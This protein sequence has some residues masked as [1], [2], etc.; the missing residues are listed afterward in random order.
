MRHESIADSES[1]FTAALQGLAHT[2]GAPGSMVDERGVGRS[3]S[4]RGGCLQG[5]L[6]PIGIWMSL[7]GGGRTEAGWRLNRLISSPRFGW[8]DWGW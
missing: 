8:V 4:T 7:L 5:E 2:D 6:K 1:G 3:S